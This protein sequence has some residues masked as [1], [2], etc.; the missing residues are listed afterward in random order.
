MIIRYHRFTFIYV[1][2]HGIF[3]L[4]VAVA[5]KKHL[6]LK[7]PVVHILIELVQE[8]VLLN[9]F[10]NDRQ[11]QFSGQHGCQC[12]FTGPDRAFHGDKRCMFH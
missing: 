3:K 5:Q 2:V 8:R 4:L 6:K 11:L 12:G 9:N 7:A 10:F 1:L